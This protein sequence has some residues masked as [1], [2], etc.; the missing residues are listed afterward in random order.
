P[1]ARRGTPPPPAWAGIIH[2]QGGSNRQLQ[3]ANNLK[4][5]GLARIPARVVLDQGDVERIRVHEKSA[6]LVTGTTSFADHA[7]SIRYA[8]EAQSGVIFNETN[9]GIEPERRLTLEIGVQAEKF[10]D[11]VEQLQ[12]IG[13]LQYVSVQQTDRTGEFRQLHARRQSLK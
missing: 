7:A 11:L 2:S 6:Q 8:V 10:D 3:M 13:H 12:R 4:Q 9:G 1:I 5:L